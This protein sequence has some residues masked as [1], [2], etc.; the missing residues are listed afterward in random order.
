M[1]TVDDLAALQAP[2]PIAA[3]QQL[4]ALFDLPSAGV[5]IRGADIYG[6]GSRAAVEIQLSNGDVMTF[7]Q[8]RD[9]ANAGIL[10]AELVACTGAIPK[11]TKATALLGVSLVRTIARH[12][13]AMS[14]N[15]AAIEWGVSYLQAADTLD[16]DL[17]DQAERWAAFSRLAEADRS[18]DPHALPANLVLRHADGTRLVRS[19]WFVSHVKAL[20]SVGSREIP[21][22]M[23]RVGWHRRGSEGRVKATRPGLRGQLNWAFFFVPVGWEDRAEALD[24][25]APVSGRGYGVTASGLVNARTQDQRSSRVEAVTDRNPVT[26]EERAA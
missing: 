23:S 15:D 5:T 1:S 25:D 6:S 3:A 13:R 10:A 24:P 18:R 9:M 8:L 11:I 26:R 4:A 22:R 7:D 21:T 12:H 17:G 19:S 14:D 20:D 16:F 2:D